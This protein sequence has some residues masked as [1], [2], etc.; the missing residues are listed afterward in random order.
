VEV[1]AEPNSL[2]PRHAKTV[3]GGND[4]GASPGIGPWPPQA[5]VI[6]A[7]VPFW[8]MPVHEQATDAIKTSPATAAARVMARQ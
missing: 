5:A 3:I 8:G 7:T 4:G 6:P 2:P 1:L